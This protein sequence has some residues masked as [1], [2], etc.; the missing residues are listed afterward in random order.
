MI[1]S[2]RATIESA[3]AGRGPRPLPVLVR[4]GAG[5]L[6]AYAARRAARRLQELDDHIL[7]DIGVSRWEIGADRLTDSLPDSHIDPVRGRAA[8]T[9]HRFDRP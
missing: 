6:K 1:G 7:R 2:T 5:L 3:G 4:L 8:E 9:L